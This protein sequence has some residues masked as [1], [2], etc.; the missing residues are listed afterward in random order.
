MIKGY[1][2]RQ[3]LAPYGKPAVD[4]KISPNEGYK[5]RTATQILLGT[6]TGTRV[7]ADMAYD[8]DSLYFVARVSDRT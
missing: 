8:L 5:T 7:A 4:G 3:L 2:V 6:Q 1:P